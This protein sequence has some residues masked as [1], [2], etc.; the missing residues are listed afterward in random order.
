MAVQPITPPNTACT[1]SPEERRG[2]GGGTLRRR[3]FKQFAWL[4]VDS[5][6]VALSRPAHQQVPLQGATQTQ[7]VGRFETKPI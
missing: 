4:E 3:V 7:T 1:R 2:R 6:K 5:D